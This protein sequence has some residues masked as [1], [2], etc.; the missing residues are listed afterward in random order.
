[1]EPVTID[2]GTGAERPAG[3]RS[4]LVTLAVALFLAMTTWF[5]ASAVLPQL[6]DRWDL[7]TSA[8]S[9]LTIAVQLGFVVGAL[10]L[11]MTSAA[12][13][14]P[15]R[16][17]IL[18][19]SLGAAM[20]NLGLLVV[21]GPASA[22]GL[23]LATGACLAAVYPP[24]MKA[25]STWFRAGRGVALGV[26]V[27]ALTLGSA[28]PHL[29][30][31]LGGMSWQGVVAITSVATVVGGLM[32][33]FAVRDGPFP[34]P[35]SGFD[36]ARARAVLSNQGV[37]LATVGYFGHMWELYA[38]WAWVGAFYAD[39]LDSARAGSLMAFLVIGV[40]AGGSVLGGVLGDRWGRV[41]STIV[42][43][44]FSGAMAG[45]IG[46][47]GNTSLLVVVGLVWGFWVV[48]DSAQFSAAVT[49]WADPESVGTALTLQLASGFVLTV[50]TIWLVP[51][52]ESRLG[53]GWAF[54]MLVP[55]PIV[56]VIAMRR[57]GELAHDPDR[58]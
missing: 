21:P 7:T 46:W 14:V 56:G 24:A 28:A 20:A 47:I 40:G 11:A 55:G 3:Q 10:V 31:T 5:S 19:G 36:P 9:W 54:A 48:A 15:P 41:P 8:A 52:V 42:S 6:R 17:L 53:W 29:V 32:A 51:V 23:R 25:M 12:D 13:V 1:M 34:F 57:L 58:Q 4:A 26:M 39:R 50:I 22:I 38:M 18:F 2:D 45:V 44:L 37:R 33:E 43:L 35:V 49:E 16:R 27:G 30:N